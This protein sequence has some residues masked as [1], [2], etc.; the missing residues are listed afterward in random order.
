[1]EEGVT[2]VKKSVKQFYEERL[3]VDSNSWTPVCYHPG[4]IELT[5]KIA[6]KIGSQQ[7]LE[8]LDVASG[9]G[10]TAYYLVTNFS[11]RVVGV[12]LSLKM[13]KYAS[14]W[15][16][17]L[18][19]HEVSFIAGDSESLPFK[20]NTFDAAIS[21]C[22]LC[23]FPDKL[24]VLKEMGRVIKPG[25]KIVISDVF[26][27][28]TLPNETNGFLLYTDCISGAETLENY[29][30]KFRKAGLINV[31]SEDVS[32]HVINLICQFLKDQ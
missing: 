8:I 22:S 21:E 23:L 17:M 5:E 18:D 26:L 4:G 3:N 10:S 30:D 24:K 20:D 12:D 2:E 13:V 16:R 27:K 9:A 29:M 15:T 25:A 11:W 1:M 32:S 6:E 31:E 28:K 19:L 14:T 7:G